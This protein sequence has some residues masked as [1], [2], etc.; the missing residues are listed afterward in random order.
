MSQ[1]NVEVFLK[2]ADAICRRDEGA[3]PEMVHPEMVRVAARYWARCGAYR[4]RA[5]Q[6]LNLRPL[7]PEASALSTE[8]R[9][10]GITLSVA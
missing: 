10:P 1:E 7:A 6:D 8:L 2:G 9:A 3:I 4:K 5:R